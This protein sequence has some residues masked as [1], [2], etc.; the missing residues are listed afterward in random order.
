[1]V[2]HDMNQVES[3]GYATKKAGEWSGEEALDMKIVAR[4]PG[5]QE[6]ADCTDVPKFV[7]SALYKWCEERKSRSDAA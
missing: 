5:Y 4:Y 2:D 7:L 1:M 3:I 6:G